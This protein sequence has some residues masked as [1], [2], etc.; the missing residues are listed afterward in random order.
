MPKFS[1]PVCIQSV[2]NII[3]LSAPRSPKRHISFRFPLKLCVLSEIVRFI[4]LFETGYN[5]LIT[6]NLKTNK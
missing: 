3:I 6:F 4:K 5:N 2:L 1:Y